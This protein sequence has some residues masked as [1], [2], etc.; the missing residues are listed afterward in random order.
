MNVYLDRRSPTRSGNQAQRYFR[1][2]LRQRTVSTSNPS[3]EISLEIK[4]W[5][6]WTYIP[7][8]QHSA[9]K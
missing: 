2:C 5:C 3:E 9:E 8:P 4:L 7:V 1:V 6:V